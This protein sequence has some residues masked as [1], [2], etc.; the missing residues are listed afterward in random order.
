MALTALQKLSITYNALYGG[1]LVLNERPITWLQEILPPSL[2]SLDI[3]HVVHT[4]PKHLDK[5]L[6]ALIADKRFS[7]LHAIRVGRENLNFPEW[8]VP[9]GWEVVSRGDC[10]E[11]WK[12]PESDRGENWEV[13]KK[14]TAGSDRGEDLWQQWMKVK[15]KNAERDEED[16]TSRVIY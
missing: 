8:D 7:A 1:Q 15:K 14:K 12:V 10:F 9:D 4:N 13:T 2:E 3:V 6:K 11:L 16:Q 5:Q